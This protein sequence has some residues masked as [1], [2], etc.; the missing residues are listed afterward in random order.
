[1]IIIVTQTRAAVV[2]ELPIDSAVIVLVVIIVFDRFLRFDRL[3]SRLSRAL[4]LDSLYHPQR[5]S[6]EPTNLIRRRN[7]NFS[8]QRAPL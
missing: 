4:P 5:Y 8:S 3:F 2:F 7:M 1:M 6:F